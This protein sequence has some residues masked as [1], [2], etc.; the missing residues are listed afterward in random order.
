MCLFRLLTMSLSLSFSLP[1][2]FSLWHRC[3]ASIIERCMGVCVSGREGLGTP[4]APPAEEALTAEH[5]GLS[6]P[7]P[8]PPISTSPLTSLLLSH[9]FSLSPSLL[10]HTYWPSFW[11]H[12][13]SACFTFHYIHLSLSVFCSSSSSHNFIYF[14]FTHDC[15]S[16]CSLGIPHRATWL[17]RCWTMFY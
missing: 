13:L 15:I 11:H 6:S 5:W 7:P 17:A 14:F 8:P 16:V 4:P 10:F 2:S 1:Q 9:L 12:S 3:K